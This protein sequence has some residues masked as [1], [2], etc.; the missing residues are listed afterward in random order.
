MNILSNRVRLT[1]AALAATMA[2]TVVPN[3][4]AAPAEPASPGNAASAQ[5]CESFTGS[6]DWGIRESFRKY[7]TGKIARGKVEFTTSATGTNPADNGFA[8]QFAP[9]AVTA[10]DDDTGTI[11]FQGDVTFTGHE[12]LLNSH[13]H[14]VRLVI[15]GTKVDIVADF[16]AA[17][18]K[19]FHAGAETIQHNVVDGVIGQVTLAKPFSF[20]AKE[21]NVLTG[22]PVVNDTNN[23]LF[24]GVYNLG[25]PLDPIGGSLTCV[26]FKEPKEEPGEGQ[27]TKPAEPSSPATTT[28]SNPEPKPTTPSTAATSAPTTS[29]KPQTSVPTTAPNAEPKPE[30]RTFR[31]FL[32]DFQGNPIGA[33]LS[34][35]SIGGLIAILTGIGGSLLNMFKR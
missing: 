11:A 25:D 18:A 4:V 23:Q 8:F 7:I 20:T 2:A 22:T 14:N 9:G 33:I 26:K 21:A 1:S 19:E 16:E 12:G 35:L 3:A 13:I 30:F 29:S 6:F 5:Y 15:D 17:E 10:Q 27:P 24:N 34:L 31:D 32:R 28:T